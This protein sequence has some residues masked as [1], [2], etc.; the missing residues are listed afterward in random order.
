M[1]AA[2]Q[3]RPPRLVTIAAE[4]ENAVEF[5]QQAVAAGVV[6]SIGH[7]A[8]SLR[9][10]TISNRLLHDVLEAIDDRFPRESTQATSSAPQ[11]AI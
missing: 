9:V 1:M 4:A 7:T 6:V 11:A 8:Q 10:A 2:W 3:V 5:I